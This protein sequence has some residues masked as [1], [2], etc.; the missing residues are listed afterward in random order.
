MTMR[1]FKIL[2]AGLLGLW[3]ASG[4]ALAAD[5]VSGAGSAGLPAGTVFQ[6]VELAGLTFAVGAN[7]DEAGAV[8]GQLHVTLLGDDAAG[9]A[10]E[11]TV[12]G[13][14]SGGELLADG[15]ATVSGEASID[16]DDGSPLET[17]VPFEALLSSPDGGPASLVLTLDGQTLPAASLVSGGV[18]FTDS[19]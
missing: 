9:S 17:G 13:E 10:R 4:V 5:G 18:T 7:W 16:A 15:T 19:E 12:E 3:L 6:D 1:R 11:I 14:I 8:T 2:C